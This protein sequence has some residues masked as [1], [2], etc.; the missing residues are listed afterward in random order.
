MAYA[1]YTEGFKSGGYDARSNNATSPPA[2]VCTAP[3]TPAGCVPVTA[4]GSFEFKPEKS[5]SYELGLK[6]RFADDRAEVNVAYF[7]TDFTN[8]QVSTFDGVLGFNVK[9]AGEAQVQGVELDARWA[10]SQYL[11]LRGS[12]VWTDF[13][14][15]NF[16]GQC[17]TGQVPNAADGIN[18][19]Y[20]G[21]TNQYVPDLAGNVALDFNMPVGAALRFGST[22]EVVYSDDYYPQATL[23]PTTIQDAYAKLNLRLALGSSDNTWEVALLGRNLTNQ[24]V[25]SNVTDMPLAARTFGAPSYGAFVE[26]PRSVAVQGTFRF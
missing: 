1:S 10:M 14:Y 16:I 22:L 9:N 26:P 13:E 3:G 4:V 2:V 5:E 7:F 19:D 12:M 8:L 20:A 17:Y 15:Q 24:T 21:K 25:T 18:C 23:D 6:S 11:S